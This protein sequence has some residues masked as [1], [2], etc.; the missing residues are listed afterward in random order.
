[1][2]AVL[3]SLFGEHPII[4]NILK[5]RELYKIIST[6]T[7]PLYNFAIKDKNSRISTSFI[8][9]GTAT[10]RLSS[11]EPN[12]QNI[13]IKSEIGRLVRKS[14][15]SKKGY[16]FLSLDYSQ[17][18]L[19]F[20]A[21]FS[22]DRT[23][24]DSFNSGEDI[25]LATSIKLFGETEA[26]EKRYIAKTI[27]FGILYGMGALK[28][29]Q[30]LKISRKEAKNIIESYFKLFP[31]I[32]EYFL[33]VNKN[34]IELGY[35]ET[36]FKRKRMFDYE[37]AN[38]IQ[39]SSFLRESINTVLQG[40]S[41]DLIKLA[42]IEIDQY[43]ESENLDAYILLQVHDELILEVKDDIVNE[44]S[45]KLKYIMEHILELKVPLLSSCKISKEW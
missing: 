23:L 15:I 22:E 1:M 37:N 19:R 31:T 12:L 38:G 45:K 8:Q 21:H 29:S 28:L 35:V 7:K 24:I 20:L 42:M 44:L 11:K 5:Y 13:P 36:I 6:Y 32:K 27:N 4:E 3:Q 33:E 14:F 25:H 41:A 34:M 26:K 40:S 18:E 2:R 10:G 43:I 30:I 39:K 16:S 17:I 9:T